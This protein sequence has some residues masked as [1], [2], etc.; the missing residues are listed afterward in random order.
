MI[1]EQGQSRVEKYNSGT[2]S[3]ILLNTLLIAD[4]ANEP[5][6]ISDFDP[7]KVAIKV[8]LKRDKQTHVIMQ[9]NL[10][11]LGT[12]A[13][14]GKNYHEFLNGLDKV[15]AA[16]GKKAVKVRPVELD[17]GGFIRLD[18]K[19]E[20]SIEVSLP[21]DGWV[22]GNINA[23][24]SYIEFDA[25]PAIGYET[26]IPFTRFEVVQANANKLGFNPGDNITKLAFLNFD[27]DDLSNEVI[28]NLS[29]SSDRWDI[30]LSFNQLLNHHASQFEGSS[31][32]RFGTALP[33]T[34][35]SP[36]VFRGLDYLPQTFILFDGDKINNE[37]DQCRVDIAFN[38]PNVNTSSNYLGYRTY[39]ADIKTVA[40]A[41]QREEKH[42]T[43]KLEKIKNS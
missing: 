18:G 23:G 34:A 27:K 20:L 38:A 13:T 43:E 14:L 24:Q 11:L 39:I 42:M 21:Q 1:V 15:Y 5:I 30:N 12:F 3:G 41:V 16:A 22:T 17:F 37:L 6:L 35:G 32:Y 26:H 33:T 19:D 10:Q 29:I 2:F 31:A 28:S 8:L 9:D 7:S 25:K 36:S 40:E 4:G